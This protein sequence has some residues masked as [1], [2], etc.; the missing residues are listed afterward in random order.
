M[1]H[2]EYFDLDEAALPIGVRA[3]AGATLDYLFRK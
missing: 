1:I 3:L 2:T